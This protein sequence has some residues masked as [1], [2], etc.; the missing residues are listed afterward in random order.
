MSK[1]RTTSAKRRTR[2]KPTARKPKPEAA[3]HAATRPAKARKVKVVRKPKT[4]PR[5]GHAFPRESG[6]RK[7][8][9]PTMESSYALLVPRERYEASIAARGGAEAARAGGPRITR[10]TIQP[11][12]GEAALATVDQTLW[13]DRIAEYRQRKAAA[14]QVEAMRPRAARRPGAVV[15]G[16]KN[17]TPLGPSVVM[18]GQAYGEPPVGGR[19]VGIAVARG[20]QRVYAASA[21]GGVFR[22][23]DAGVSWRS[24]MDEFDLDPTDFASTS[25]ACGAIA[26]DLDNPD[27]V[28]VGTGEGDTYAI[29][30]QRITNALPAYRGIGPIRSDD[31]GATWITESAATGSP[32]LAGKAFFALALDPYHAENVLSATT[33][34]LYQR[35]VDASGKPLWTQRRPGVHP[36]VVATCAAGATRFFCS[37]WGKGVFQ[38]PDGTSWTPVGAGFPT[39]DVGRIALAVQ[40]TNTGLVYAMVANGKGALLGVYRIELAQG[41]WKKIVNP[42]DVLPVDDGGGSQGDYDL[43][44]AVDP[45]DANLIYIGGSY[46]ADNMYWPA[47]IWRCRVGK[48]GSGYRMTSVSI[49]TH[50]H[51]DVHILTHTPDNSDALW[52]G[53]DGGVFLNRAPRGS[54][55]F[56]SC[57]NGLACL[58][59]NF[60][61]QHP[62]DPSLL[63]CGLQDNGTARTS[64]GGLWKNVNGGDGGYC[65]INW[66]DPQ[67]VLVF[68][69]GTVSRAT[70]G[71]Q[72]PSSWTDTKFPWA[73]M[74]EPIVGAPYDPSKP[75][76]GNLAAI[77][78]GSEVHVSNDFGASWPNT[79]PV[80]TKA[81]MF[82]LTFASNSMLYAGTTKG[83]V[84]R[85]VKRGSNWTEAQIDN[86]AAGPLGLY[87]M[88][89]D[90]AI[91]W[92]DPSGNSVYVAFSGIGDYRHVWHF[93]GTR[94]K[95]ASGMGPTS[96][97]DVEHNAIAV[98]RKNPDNVYVGADIG[99]WHSS[100]RGQTWKPLAN[101]LPDAP[102]FD[103]QIH[104]TQ[105]LLRVTTH[106]RG[107]FEYPLDAAPLATPTVA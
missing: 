34:G 73:M 15:P 1:K 51:A 44:I 26:I 13:I 65:L 33:D 89:A 103:L 2:L 91:D 45:A 57:N 97:L 47:S 62:T 61:A 93:D 3:E 32:S 11:E 76:N 63:F 96:L 60:F 69:N 95:A 81:G 28:F 9:L 10:S 16:D 94:W 49:G 84:F 31:G 101:G 83:E 71:G 30:R 82:A 50:A 85:F 75:A 53:C 21:N 56:N 18:N 41:Q 7:W 72:G 58:C 55:V 105:R 68:A 78:A 6:P 42:P 36:S 27:R 74:T 35:A 43:T 52:A 14:F 48:S 25:L 24:L 92:T 98:D 106:G 8:L 80:S 79:I 54:G 66:N 90:I 39:G 86:A 19:V 5:K 38:S 87:G 4:I 67:Q 88:I 40:P 64:G 46:F 37:E 102:V 23:D 29:F 77:G 12:R 107:M 20:G 70:D 99:V 59:T 100:D 104:P 22:S 17:W